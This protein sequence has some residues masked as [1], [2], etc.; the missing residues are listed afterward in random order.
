VAAYLAQEFPPTTKYQL[1][2]VFALI[3]IIDEKR[4]NVNTIAAL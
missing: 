4:I 2:I 1:Q 3:Y